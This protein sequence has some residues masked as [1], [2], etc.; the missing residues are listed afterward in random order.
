MSENGQSITVV[1]ANVPLVPEAPPAPADILAVISQAVSDPRLDVG[2]MERLLAMYKEVTEENRKVAFAAAKARLKAKL[3]QIDKLGRIV[4]KGQERSRY[5]KYEDIDVIIS[6]LM[7]EEGFSF[8]FDSESK[9]GRLYEISATLTHREGHSET[10]RVLVPL[11]AN[12]FRT[13]VQS[14]GSTISYGKRYL[15]KMH[16]NLVERDEDDDGNGGNKP[17][18][19]DQALDLQ[20]K[21]EEVGADKRRFLDF[22]GVESLEDITSKDFKKALNALESKRRK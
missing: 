3:P 12:D 20:A 17:I 14:V 8:S 5:A 22:L 11:D 6:P 19:K 18:T 13:N 2:K 16:L 21:I 1:N 7:A 15:V 9:D 4:V 10:K